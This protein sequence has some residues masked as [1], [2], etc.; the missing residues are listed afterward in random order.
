VKQPTVPPAA[1]QPLQMHDVASAADM[2]GICKAT[3]YRLIRTGKLVASK[4]G[5]RTLISDR[6]LREFVASI[7]VTRL[8]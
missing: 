3:V 4:I 6:R 2:L 8:S 1:P 7:E 5:D